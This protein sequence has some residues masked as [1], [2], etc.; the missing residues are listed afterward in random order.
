MSAVPVH[1]WER[2]FPRRTARLPALLRVGG[3]AGP[4]HRTETI[5]LSGTGVLLRSAADAAVGAEVW[6]ALD[7]GDAAVGGQARVMRVGPAGESGLRFERMTPADREL[8][9]DFVLERGTAEDTPHRRAYPRVA[10]SRSVRVAA[11]DPDVPPAVTHTL[12]VSGGGMLLAGPAYLPVGARVW[13]SVDLEDGE[14]PIRAAGRI[15]R[16]GAGGSRGM[17]FD[18]IAAHDRSR[19]VA[20]CMPRRRRGSALPAVRR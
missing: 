17:A 16:E 3:P 10:A 13:T 1:V 5:D 14:P 4:A 12:D 20:L 18:Q 6:L 9:A 11:G 2:S 15:V 19:L 7:L 8:L